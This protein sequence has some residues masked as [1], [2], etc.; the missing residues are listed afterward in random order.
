MVVY[1]LWGGYTKPGSYLTLPSLFILTV[2]IV[3][4]EKSTSVLFLVVIVQFCSRKET[5]SLCNHS[6]VMSDGSLRPVLTTLLLTRH[7]KAAVIL[8]PSAELF[9]CSTA[10]LS[11]PHA[12]FCLLVCFLSLVLMKYTKPNWRG[13]T[14]LTSNT[15][16]PASHLLLLSV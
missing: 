4:C 3:Y 7:D 15:P 5:G 12:L 10:V 2:C 8:Q 11:S 6:S 14:I 9:F 1:V 13:I 16:L